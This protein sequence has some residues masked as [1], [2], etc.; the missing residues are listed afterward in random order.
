M[1]RQSRWQLCGHC[2]HFRW[3]TRTTSNVVSDYEVVK[4]QH[5]R[6]NGKHLVVGAHIYFQ[7]ELL[8]TL[9][10]W[11]YANHNLVKYVARMAVS[12]TLMEQPT[13]TLGLLHSKIQQKNARSHSTRINVM[14]GLSIFRL[15]LQN[16]Q[17]PTSKY[18]IEMSPVQMAVN[19][20]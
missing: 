6:F 5:F 7:M 10:F 12:S 13:V 2:L 17:S 18:L 20:R 19:Y 14:K 9:V 16:N 4:W 3:S 8:S 15:L 1:E 11:W